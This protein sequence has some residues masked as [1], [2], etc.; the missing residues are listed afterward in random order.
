MLSKDDGVSARREVVRP[1]RDDLE[2][3]IGEGASGVVAVR[4][5]DRLARL[6]PAIRAPQPT[7]SCPLSLC[8]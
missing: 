2:R 6:A 7:A 4:S 1:D 5:V 3:L 8:R